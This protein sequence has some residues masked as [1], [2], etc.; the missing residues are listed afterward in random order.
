LLHMLPKGFV[1]IRNF[2]YLA[3]RH[4][5]T[6]LPRCFQC[7]ESAPDPSTAEPQPTD[8]SGLWK[9]PQCGGPM[10]VILRVFL[11]RRLPRPPPAV[12]VWA[13][14]IVNRVRREID[15]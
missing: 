2:G 14:G 6:L 4:R 11:P 7:L 1:R 15:Q 10:I 9:C 13:H 12:H 5:R 8:T 3:N